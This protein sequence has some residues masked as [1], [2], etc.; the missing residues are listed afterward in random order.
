[1]HDWP[2]INGP[3]CLTTRDVGT[4]QAFIITLPD[5]SIASFSIELATVGDMFGGDTKSF[6]GV[7][8]IGKRIHEIIGTY[9]VR[10]KTGH[11]QTTAHS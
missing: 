5:N 2:I 1:M 7:L 4:S 11:C 6:S 8:R 9:N 10:E 3:A